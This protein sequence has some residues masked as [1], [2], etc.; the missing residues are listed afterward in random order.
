VPGTIGG[1]TF[2]RDWRWATGL[3]RHRADACAIVRIGHG[4]W[5]IENQGP[6]ELVNAWHGDHIYRNHPAAIEALYLLLCLAYNLFHALLT[7]NL[8]P[9]LRARYTASLIAAAIAADFSSVPRF[10][11]PP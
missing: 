8:K 4:R 2:L 3:P 1:R 11:H 7:R 6:N 10:A 5:T 9:A